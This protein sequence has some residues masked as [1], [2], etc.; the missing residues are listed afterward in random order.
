[1]ILFGGRAFKPTDIS[2]AVLWVDATQ[3]SGLSNNDPVVTWSDLTSSANHLTQGTAAKRPTYKT[4]LI[5]GKPGVQFDGTDDWLGTSGNIV[6]GNFT[7]VIA[8]NQ[9]AAERYIALHGNWGTPANG[10]YFWSGI[11]CSALVRRDFLDWGKTVGAAWATGLHTLVFWYHRDPGV[12]STITLYKDNVSQT[13]AAC[14]S[15]ALADTTATQPFYVAGSPGTGVFGA[16][17]DV[18]EVILYNRQLTTPELTQ[19]Q[20]YLKPKWGTP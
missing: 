12:G 9:V 20:N 3:I 10:C 5:N 13:L 1:M 8:S 19:L 4:G 6:L 11:N 17:A 7:L 16:Q 2:G 15:T 18:G 14:S